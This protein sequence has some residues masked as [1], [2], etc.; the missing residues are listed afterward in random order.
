MLLLLLSFSFDL[1]VFVLFFSVTG[2][3]IGFTSVGNIRKHSGN[4]LR[5]LGLDGW[6]G[7]WAVEF[8]GRHYKVTFFSFLWPPS[9]NSAVSGLV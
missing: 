2:H 1:F 9:L 5:I 8:S 7:R 6:K 4:A 3:L